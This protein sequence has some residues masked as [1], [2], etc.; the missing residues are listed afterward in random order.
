MLSSDRKTHMPNNV[1][2]GDREY[3][4]GIGTIPFEGRGSDTPLAFMW[5]DPKLVVA[6]K[7]LEDHMRFAVAY[8]HRF[9]CFKEL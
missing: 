4:P 6:G 9:C 5:Y 8:W 7:P 3:F 2:L 1:T